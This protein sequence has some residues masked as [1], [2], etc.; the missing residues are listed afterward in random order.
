MNNVVLTLNRGDNEALLKATQSRQ[1]L[2]ETI[3]EAWV[4]I[5]SQKNSD[6]DRRKLQVVKK[7]MENGEIGREPVADDKKPKRFSKAEALRLYSQLVAMQRDKKLDDIVKN[8]PGNYL[9]VTNIGQL[10]KIVM[11]IFESEP[12]IA[13][14]TET[15][16]LDVYVD[17]IIG[18]SITL[19]NADLH[20]YIPIQPTDDERALEP[21]IVFEI[22]KPLME[23][24]VEKVLHNAIY[25]MN[26]FARHGIELANV[27]WDTMTA[28]HMLNENEPSYQLKKL[29]TKYLDE[30]SDTFE[31]LFGKNAQFAD[32][33][34]DVALAYAAKDTDLTWRL[35]EFQL[36]HL[37]KLPTIL[38][39]YKTVEVPLMYA[40]YD[41]ERTGFEIDMEYAK[42]YGKEMKAEIE[43]LERSLTEKF[44]G[45]NIN[46]NQQLKPVLEDM[47]GFELENLD[48]KKTLK[49]LA[50][51]HA[52]VE[53]LLQYR[54]LNKLFS[55]Y[56]SVLPEKVHP[57]TGRVHARF[58]P[59]GARTGR[60][61]SGG[62]GVNLQNQPYAARKLFVAPKG[63]AIVGG[64]FS[65]Q[66]IRC[67]A[68]KTGEPLLIDAFNRGRD[69]YA[70]LASEF[71]KKPYEEVYKN[72]DDSD[73][74]ER[75]MMKTGMLACLYGTGKNTLATQLKCSPAEA[76]SFLD[77]FFA[78]YKYIKRWIDETKQF[79]KKN[80]FVWLDNQQRK[81]RLPVAKRLTHGYDWEVAAAL[82][83]GPNA[84]IQGTSAIQSKK[85]LVNLHRLCKE[86]GW[87]LWCTV[88]DEILV[89]MP[90]DFTMDDIKAF[91]DVMINSYKFGDIPNKTDIE[92]SLRW[93]EG[94]S[95][96]EW[97]KRKETMI[98]EG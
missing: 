1:A 2:N 45:I 86:R 39:Y 77:D 11:Q 57:V 94:V 3:D 10:K 69:P 76:Q 52:I 44:G 34:L 32:V 63:Y 85:T 83:Q 26:M 47:L 73:T 96:S 13:L 4:R 84:V 16:G 98:H 20:V 91:E 70:T 40:V 30:P 78:R 95:V 36:E 88:H 31:E 65:A 9:L 27:V 72:P 71:F 28:M 42:T 49:P 50:K 82:R 68:Y 19:P 38:E 5:L 58:N 23:S 67:A 14:D 51:Q 43:Q 53:E 93:G 79:V 15:T 56:I 60:F 35:Y 89:L 33:P 54:E 7:A 46:S 41:M 48:A 22:I 29:A 97:F 21:K 17:V 37:S 92:I 90:I 18:V 24:D 6:A 25:D 87:L 75:K 8:M 59:N 81:R 74:V 62:N 12:S 66:E 61:S 64:D 80:G 55:T